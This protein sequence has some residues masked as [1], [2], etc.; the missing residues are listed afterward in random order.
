M[1]S[2][3]AA[4]PRRAGLLR[5]AVTAVLG[6]SGRRDVAPVR[7]SWRDRAAASFE[8]PMPADHALQFGRAFQLPPFGRGNGIEALFWT[9]AERVP[10]ERVD[11]VL[12]EL[13]GRDIA[14]WAAPARLPGVDRRSVDAPHDLWVVA[15]RFDEAQDVVMRMLRAG[16]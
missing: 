16:A 1:S 11:T 4:A 2:R 7:A 8:A 10:A 5:Y 15:D 9:P 6:I 12:T 13:R 14:A 3:R